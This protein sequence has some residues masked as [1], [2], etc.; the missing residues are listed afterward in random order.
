MVALERDSIAVFGSRVFTRLLGFLS[1]IYFARALGAESLGIYFT[2]QTLVSILTLA[3]SVGLPG[4]TVKR[5]SQQET[6]DERAP[7]LTAA[8]LLA[9][10]TFGIVSLAVFVFGAR[11]D[12]FVDLETAAPLLVLVVG[13]GACR[14]ILVSALRGEQKVSVSGLLDLF[15]QVV[16]LVVSIALIAEFGVVGLIYG[17]AVSLALSALVSFWLLDTSLTLPTRGAI[18]HLVE[19]ARYTAGMNVSHLAYTWA[20]TLVLAA[21]ASKAAVGVYESSWRLTGITLLG[22]QAIGIALA[23]T[24]TRWHENGDM[25]GIEQAFRQALTYAV[26]FVIP[27]IV[28][29]A[30]LGDDLLSTLYQ[31]ETG[32]TVLLILTVGQLA[33]AVKYV[34]QNVLF[35]ID[36]PDIVFWT[37]I[38]SLVANLALNVVLVSEFGIYGAAV[39]TLTTAAVAAVAQ[40][41]LLRRELTLSADWGAIGW[42]VGA[43]LVMGAAI[44][45]LDRVVAGDTIV[46]VVSLVGAGAV[47]YGLGMLAREDV[48]LRLRSA[49]E[50]T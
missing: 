35:G 21:L 1:V 34:T 5:M 50:S 36:R 37:N 15:G 16:R 46:G 45:A 25:D 12:S 23:P 20:D 24:I 11:V 2:F 38:V 28:G 14:S 6:A 42:Q 48:R 49:L 30:L 31:F 22:A 10:G 43:A 33:Q 27:A 47:V 26:M 41:W 39:A 18:E 32:A 3:A 40:I 9:V 4:A 13:L 8:L 7:Y 19:F 17:S 44:Y 29:V